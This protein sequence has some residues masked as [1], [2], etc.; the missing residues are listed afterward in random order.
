MSLGPIRRRKSPCLLVASVQDPSAFQ[1]F[2]RAYVDGVVAY[3]TRRT[4]DAELALDLTGETF[5]LALERRAQFRGRLPQEEQGWLFA[6]ARSQLYRYY[7]SGEVERAALQRVG[8]DAP[9]ATSADLEYVERLIDRP[10]LHA[11]V[12]EALASLTTDQ[13]F[14]VCQRVLEERSYA[15]MAI[16][17]GVSEQ[18]V[19]ARVSRG[20]KQLG[21]KLGD[22]RLQDIA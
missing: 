8:L 13:A 5:A 15:E 21:E 10:A 11:A 17:L 22:Y 18:V 19:R 2:Y 9:H 7:R 14:A 20:L 1:D 4:F 12:R 6:I 16:E 3:F